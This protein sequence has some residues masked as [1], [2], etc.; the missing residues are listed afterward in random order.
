MPRAPGRDQRPP[1]P[2]LKTYTVSRLF[3]RIHAPRPQ[4]WPAP[5]STQTEDLHCVATVSEDTCPA[6]P[7]MTSALLDPDWRLA[8][9]RGC[10]RGYMPRAPGRDQRPPRPRLKTYTVSRL[11]QRLHAPR[12]QSWPAPSSTPTEGLHCVATVSEV[13]CPAPPVVTS[14]LLDPDCAPPYPVGSSCVYSCEER[15]HLLCGQQ[16]STHCRADGTWSDI[17]AVCLGGWPSV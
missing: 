16:M 5:S 4:S 12:P 13:T 3:Q 1:R 8:L 6:P 7:I 11:F 15:H 2:R 14:A 9:C 10:F 17:A